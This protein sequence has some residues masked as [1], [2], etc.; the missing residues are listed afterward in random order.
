M[1]ELLFP[2][3]IALSIFAKV[4]EIFGLRFSPEKIFAKKNWHIEIKIIKKVNMR[5]SVK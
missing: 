3:F 4:N 1:G 2:V 5:P